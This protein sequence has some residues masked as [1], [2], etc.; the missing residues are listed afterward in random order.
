[1]GSNNQYPPDTGQPRRRVALDPTAGSVIGT[2]AGVSMPPGE[3][4]GVPGYGVLASYLVPEGGKVAYGNGFQTAAP[5]FYFEHE[6][7]TKQADEAQPG[8]EYGITSR[9]V[10]GS[11]TELYKLNG[12]AYQPR[13]KP[14]P[15][16]QP[17]PTTKQI[18]TTQASMPADLLPSSEDAMLSLL[19][20]F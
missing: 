4:G 16:A 1:M 8:D 18:V 11:E 5:A 14:Q 2:Q 20:D 6:P 15:A 3:T 9:P 19:L 12:L 10:A 17:R 13:A 7:A